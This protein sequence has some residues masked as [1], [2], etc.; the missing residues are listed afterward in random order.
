MHSRTSG[1]TSLKNKIIVYDWSTSNV[2][3]ESD[4]VK[5]KM[6]L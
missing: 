1:F 5:R 3:H 6:G 2:N 4:L